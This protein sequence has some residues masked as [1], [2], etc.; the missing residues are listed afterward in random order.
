MDT[1]KPG[2]WARRD[3][4]EVSKGVIVS[5]SEYTPFSDSAANEYT[6]PHQADSDL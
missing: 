5:H 3:A 1:G 6:T 4:K 2:G